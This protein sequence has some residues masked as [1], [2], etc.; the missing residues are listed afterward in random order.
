MAC[1][2]KAWVGCRGNVGRM[3]WKRG[4]DAVLC[5]LDAVEAWVGC[6]TPKTPILG[7]CTSQDRAK[8]RQLGRSG[9]RRMICPA[10]YGAGR[11]KT[12][13]GCCRSV[14]RMPY[15]VGRMPWKRGS[16]AVS[17]GVGLV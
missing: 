1:E 14:G 5:G 3:P 7:G 2:I 17:N 11:G 8:N 12:G 16:D 9:V 10:K 13:F 6:R 4:S 15:F